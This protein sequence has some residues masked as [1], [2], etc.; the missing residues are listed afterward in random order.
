MVID[1]PPGSEE[2]KQPLSLHAG[3]PL[4]EALRK[5]VTDGLLRSVVVRIPGPKAFFRS[6]KPWTRV[7]TWC[8]SSMNNQIQELQFED[9][10]TQ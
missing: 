8:E 10:L 2:R 5:D 4:N 1:I 3:V 9:P 6:K 7:P